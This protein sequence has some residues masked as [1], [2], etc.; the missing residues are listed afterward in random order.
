MDAVTEDSPTSDPS[1]PSTPYSRWA[2]IF[3]RAHNDTHSIAVALEVVDAIRQ[4]EGSDPPPITH[5]VDRILAIVAG[6]FD[7]PVKRLR[8]RSRR[9]DVT[10]ARYVAAMLLRQRRWTTT[11]L[12]DYFGL[13]HS[14][15]VCGLQKVANTHHLL[16]A[17]AK[18]EQLLRVEVEGAP[19]I[20]AAA[21][22]RCSR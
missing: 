10:S 11:K 14:T 7:M 15:I 3:A 22:G 8:E 5:E 2:E 1:E 18:A 4:H 12:G 13:D 19:V 20:P 9:Q 17:A 21:K 6:L 16:I